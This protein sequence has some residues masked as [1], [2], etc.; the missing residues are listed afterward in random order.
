MEIEQTLQIPISQQPNENWV[1]KDI[2]NWMQ[3]NNIPFNREDSHAI[4]LSKIQ[5]IK[6]E[7]EKDI[8]LVQEEKYKITNSNEIPLST[9]ISGTP[10]T[11]QKISLKLDFYRNQLHKW[12]QEGKHIMAQFTDDYI[13]VYQAFKPSI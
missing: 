9:P 4:L 11:Q 13:T 7:N 6:K 1:T 5:Q 2:K 3:K 12:P 10:I 8:D